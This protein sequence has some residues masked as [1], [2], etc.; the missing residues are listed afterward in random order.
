MHFESVWAT[1]RKTIIKN[2][3]IHNCKGYCLHINVANNMDI[4]NNVFYHAQKY[5]LYIDNV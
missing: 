2:S 1:G 3:A 4:F 5:H